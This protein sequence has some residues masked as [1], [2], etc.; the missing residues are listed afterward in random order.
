MKPFTDIL[1][2][3][4]GGEVVTLCT[5]EFASLLEKVAEHRKPGTFTLT[6][7]VQPDKMGGREVELHSDVSIK[8]PRRVPRPALFFTTDQN[9]LVRDNP[10]QRPLF[11][12][13]EEREAGRA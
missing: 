2:E 13:I 12:E 1:R 3:C 10:D 6:I 9:D 4:R 5:K 7:K 11:E 8:P